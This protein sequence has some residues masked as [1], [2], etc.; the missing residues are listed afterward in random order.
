MNA[1]S[2]P[3]SSPPSLQRSIAWQRQSHCFNS[4]GG[5][6]RGWNVA[7]ET[8][9]NLP[10]GWKKVY[11]VGGSADQLEAGA[12]EVVVAS[13]RR[14]TASAVSAEGASAGGEPSSR[15][16]KSPGGTSSRPG[17]RDSSALRQRKGRAQSDVGE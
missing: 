3:W 12:A 10:Q 6:R 16:N 2:T 9:P 1:S 8:D 7:G 11:T 5:T 4:L 13:P 17:S 14:A 15:A